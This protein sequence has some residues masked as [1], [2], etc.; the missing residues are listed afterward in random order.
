[1]IWSVGMPTPDICDSEKNS[2]SH[3]ALQITGRGENFQ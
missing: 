1:M 3:L 2:E